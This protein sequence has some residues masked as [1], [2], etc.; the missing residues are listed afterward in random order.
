MPKLL[1]P[2]L[3]SNKL[4][5]SLLTLLLLTLSRTMKRDIQIMILISL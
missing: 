4:I 3:A 1:I 2:L 5:H